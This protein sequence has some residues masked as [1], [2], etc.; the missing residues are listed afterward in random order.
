MAAIDVVQSL[1]SEP[2]L[3]QTELR[4]LVINGEAADANGWRFSVSPE[5]IRCDQDRAPISRPE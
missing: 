1:D 5:C 3:S 4:L 2:G